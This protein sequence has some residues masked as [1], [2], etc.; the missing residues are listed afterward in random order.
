[1]CSSIPQGQ[2]CFCYTDTLTKV[3]AY[4]QMSHLNVPF[5]YHADTTSS[6]RCT[7]KKHV[8][9]PLNNN[10]DAPS[11]STR[12]R[13]NFQP[14]LDHRGDHGVLNIA[15]PPAASSKSTSEFNTTS[16]TYTQSPRTTTSL[17]IN[18]RQGLSS[19]STTPPMGSQHSR[20][21]PSP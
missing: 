15:P 13:C 21:L 10:Q 8:C 16:N 18:K 3:C 1:M 11:P 12:R 7:E 5:Q 2:Q 20:T 17:P 9:R 19:L 4:T 6:R 14:P